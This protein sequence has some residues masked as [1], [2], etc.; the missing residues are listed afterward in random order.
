[1]LN[2]HK[3][4]LLIG[5]L[6]SLVSAQIVHFSEDFENSTNNWTVSGGGWEFGTPTL[7]NL[8]PLADG[9]RCA[10]T[11]LNGS[12]SSSINYILTSPSVKLPNSPLIRLS[13]YN[14]YELESSYDYIYLEI[15]V[16]NSSNWIQLFSSSATSTIWSQRTV[17]LSQYAGSDVQIRFR[18]ATDGSV[19]RLGWYID[20]IK[21]YTPEYRT[22]T[23][24][25]SGNGT[26]SPATG[27]TQIEFGM[28]TPIT[29]TPAAGYRFDNWTVQSGN[30]TI[31][32]PTSQT[33]N[34]TITSDAVIQA[35]FT[36]GTLYPITTTSATYNFTTHYFDVQVANGVRF[37]FT[38][39]A[40]G[41]YSIVVANTGSVGK[42]IYYYGTSSTFSSYIN[43]QSGTATLYYNFNASAPGEIHYFK[44]L[45]TSNSYYTSSFNINYTN[46]YAVSL[47]SDGNGTVNPSSAILIPG[48]TQ[49][50]NATPAAGYRFN[51]WTIENGNATI[52]SPTSQATSV[53][54][55]S[56]ATVKANFIAGT[57]YP[58]TATSATYNFTTH[59]FDVQVANGVR[60]SF[61][62]P[63]AGNY[64]IVVANS[65]SVGK[66][67][68]Y[69]GTSSA[70]SSYINYQSG[71]ATLNYNFNASA[72]GEIHYFKVL[73]TSSSYYTS[74][75]NINYV[76]ANSLTIIT[77]GNGTTSP[78]YA[79]LAPGQTQ[80]IN[81]SPSA[82]YR[83]RSWTVQSGNATITDTNATSTT[84][85]INGNTTIIA[86]FIAGTV[87]PVTI[88]PATFNF[89]THYYEV[90]PSYGVRLRFTA[91]TPGTYAL[92]I[93]STYSN[94]TYYR[95]D[96]TFTSLSGSVSSTS[97]KILYPF[98]ATGSNE[99][100]YFLIRP[101]STTYYNSNFKANV[102]SSVKLKILTSGNG[103]CFPSDSVISCWRDSDTLITA[104]PKGGYRFSSWSVVSGNAIIS[105]TDSAK[106]RVRVTSDSATIRATFTVDP[107]TRPKITISDINISSHPDIC[108]TALVTDSAG[109]SISG[110]DTSNFSLMQD[111]SDV[112]YQL[113]Q[114]SEI[115]GVSVALVIDRSG[116]MSTTMMNDAKNAARQYVRTMGP[117][118]RSAIIT[119][120]TTANVEQAITSDTSL[121]IS[122]INNIVVDDMTAILNGTI[123]GL[124]QLSNETN[125]RAVIVFSD[126]LD[127]YS[128]ISQASVINY[129]REHNTTIYS[130][131]IG[132]SADRNVLGALA[133][134]T[135]G[136][137]TAAPSAADLARIYAQI[138][139]DIEAKYILCYRSPD[140]IF[141]GDTHQVVA[142]VN[143]N[144]H[145]DRDTVYWNENNQPPLIQ[146]TATTQ[147]M[148]L[149]SQP[150]NQP[151]T[152]SANVTDDGTISSVRLFYRNSNL[153]SGSY[154]ELP[155]Q[156]SSGSIYQATIP[157]T[158]VNYPG[159]DFYIL[160]TDNYQLIGRSPNILAP[161]TQP[162]V[163]P[164]GNNAPV[165]SDLQTVCL[166]IGNDNIISAKID[167][168]NGI[169]SAI[170]YYKK[171][172]E[173]FF[174]LDTMTG[175]LS[176]FYTGTIPSNMITN[177]GIDYYIRA[178]DDAGAASRYP[179]LNNDSLFPCQ[180]N[181]LPPK[182]NAGA[183]INVYLS[184][185]CDT[186]ITLNG[187]A[188]SDPDGG[189]ISF[190]WTGPFSDTL[191]GVT[192]SVNLSVGQHTIF[193]KVTD[194]SGLYDL[195]TV[196][197]SVIDTLIPVFSLVPA[198]TVVVI[199]AND[200]T[201]QITIDSAMATDN[202]ALLS[203]RAIRSDGL[204]FG[205]F[206][207]TGATSISWIALDRSGN[208]DTVIQ[209]INVRKNR[210]PVLTVPADTGLSEG[211][212]LNISVS[213]TDPDNTNPAISVLNSPDWLTIT[214][215]QNNAS[216]INIAPGCT[217][218][219]NHQIHLIA[220]DL[221]D[222]AHAVFNVKIKDVNFPPVFDSLPFELKIG[223][224]APFELAVRVHDCDGTIPQIKMLTSVAGAAFVDNLNSTGTFRW[225]P[226]ADDYGFY[227]FIFEATD[228]VNNPVRDTIIIEVTDI[229]VSPPVLVVSSADTTS[230][231][232]LPLIIVAHATDLDGTAPVLKGSQIPTGAT[233]TT[234][235]N[236]N[237]VFSWTPR[238]TGTFVILIT[239]YDQADP[240]I[241]DSQLV[242]I[243]INNNNVTGPK[244]DPHPSVSI[245]QNE[246]LVL[247][248][249]AVDQDGTKP[250]LRLISSAQG[251]RFRDNGDG[252]A[253]VTWSPACDVSGTFIF[254]ASATDGK[255]GD[256]IEIPVQ[257][258]DVN[259][260]P[261]LFRCAD[262]NAQPGERVSIPIRAYDPDNNGSI[263][264]LSVSCQLPEF[265]F[266][267]Q[268][269][270]SAFFNWTVSYTTG[271]YPVTFYA[272]DGNSTDSM[273]I[274]ISINKTGSLKISA[275]PTG[276]HIYAFPSDCY[277]GK[278][279]GVDSTVYSG[280][281]GCQWFE[282]QA[283]GYRSRRVACNI[284][285]DTTISV[286]IDLKPAIPLMVLSPDTVKLGS[287]KQLMQNGSIS[288]AD[289]NR[290]H[291]LDLSVATTSGIICFYGIDSTDNSLFSPVPVTFFAGTL[292]PSLHHTFINWNNNGNQSC[293][294]STKTGKILRINLKTSAIDTL[295]SIPGSRLYPTIFDADRDGRKDLV[296]NNAGKGLFVYLNTG[297]DS[298]P[299]IAFAK[300]CTTPAGLPLTDLNGAVLLL[301]SDKDGKEEVIVFSAGVLKLFEPDSIFST[302]TYVENLSC[303][304]NLVTA[305][306]I[307]S[308]FIGST[309][310]IS[311]FALRKANQILIYPTQLQG[312]ITFDGKV[313]IR[314]V[315]KAS[316]NWEFTPDNPSWDPSINVK[317]SESGNEKI[318]IRDISRISKNWE[319]QQ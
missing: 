190:R 163:I 265:S 131:G 278:Q 291:I 229:N 233:F 302:L 80:S 281:P 206:F 8:L 283:P 93:D 289:L 272:T 81:A 246:N 151:L 147:A 109:R 86:N 39:P 120:H 57:M 173:T 230:S 307:S 141:N 54:I 287:S 172:N 304:G 306:S 32:S 9:T 140:Q 43:Y 35:N 95:N 167:D 92:V 146:L 232:N 44:V 41:N 125:T 288:F 211:E 303:G 204:P 224:A 69:Y 218:N 193:L 158:N 253:T 270:G 314:D 313:D 237:G 223:E 66:Y 124:Q 262:I 282:F 73:P 186:V 180:N 136:Y 1:M 256:T 168:D 239:A 49:S 82:G 143:L 209:N 174:S 40:A 285:A 214:P 111:N 38:A 280:T 292:E 11:V 222:T 138:K 77:S 88:S 247:N 12:Y 225:T 134:S 319:L 271:T 103:L 84:I 182:A 112:N 212:I 185:G 99:N 311:S 121:L 216:T 261:I 297:S 71:T 130:I 20:Q 165:I 178:V 170:L 309:T 108:L 159:V 260:A 198:D 263:P 301:D 25:S 231:V 196:K 203:V 295:I 6:F 26:T 252:T 53:S 37:S 219:G 175:N 308:S 176:G 119:F 157:A 128:T 42:Y 279:I 101:A 19:V 194:N 63:A 217:D 290:D 48:Q 51:N 13:F 183:D 123:L 195:D 104:L 202:C 267:T 30:A 220:T 210:L 60:F 90:S 152:I 213:A 46:A 215:N 5:I 28:A 205:S 296:V 116:S 34:V 59:Y 105:S 100:H 67:I 208:A 221:L 257:V 107:A 24:Q 277:R 10:G 153:S 251:A 114:V 155:M 113:T 3:F 245:Q 117:L 52:T 4:P 33:T 47:T 78:S 248:L 161:E 76:N 21:I 188:S 305:D 150:S 56:N 254:S 244:F 65:G 142:S 22:L 68:Y 127:N 234:D 187:S 72:P 17:D 228:N 75:F 50:I 15:Q 274:F 169:S 227:M 126:G 275:R 242:T 137:Y 189:P 110:L 154:T 184:S 171:R 64:S 255:F 162:W 45:P 122:A 300:E 18:L 85:S 89:T 55:T 36:A 264:V 258:R 97:A 16:N 201:C 7:T 200:S 238:D 83:L 94:M 132:S 102:V 266:I 129:A 294:L 268:S 312:D 197:I 87:Y 2:V 286:T 273:R 106:T 160:A 70:F 299:A 62:A 315:S 298:V 310:G 293:L 177:S 259:C 139:S 235:N 58:I 269:D 226:D 191:T 249:R 144:N 79:I 250:V 240:T 181:N 133:D 243:R 284:K 135:G 276:S 199:R 61:T 27:N 192:P 316:M 236:G 14:W 317:L 29:A 149:T 96:S 31:A 145:I 74:S 118:D 179:S 318:D 115:A 98:T 164:V 23:M 91:P 207:K 166:T 156:I 148:L 241:Y